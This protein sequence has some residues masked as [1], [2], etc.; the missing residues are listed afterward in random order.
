MDLEAADGREI[1][2]IATSEGRVAIDAARRGLAVAAVDDLLASGRL[3]LVEVD[4]LA[5]PRK[6]LGHRRAIG[7]LTPD[8]SDRL[9]RVVRVVA[10]AEV[11]FGSREKAHRWLRRPTS[12][13]EGDAP[14]DWL[15][16]SEGCRLVERLL[17]RIDH[18]LAA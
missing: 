1:V 16:T 3:T 5:A 11:T 10:A 7:S 8:P 13:L 14:L 12:A 9:L 6:T 4:R 17:G 18:R 15:D 2:V